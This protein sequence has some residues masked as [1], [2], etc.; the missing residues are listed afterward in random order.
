MPAP[1][2]PRKRAAI[3]ADIDAGMSCRAASRKHG[4]SQSTVSRLAKDH[5]RNFER[6]QTKKATEAAKIDHAAVLVKLAARSASVAGDILASFEA[7]GLDDWKAVSPHTRAIALGI[8]ADK[9]RELA[10]DDD[11]AQ[12]AAAKSVLSAVLDNLTAKHGDGS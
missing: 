5:D 10:P 12:A 6:S 1:L 7:M 4:V 11:E 2:A 9:A 8:C 3:L